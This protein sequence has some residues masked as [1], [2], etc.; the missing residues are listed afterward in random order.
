MLSPVQT[1]NFYGYVK[2]SLMLMAS[3]LERTVRA[4]PQ[5]NVVAVSQQAVV[6]CKT[7]ATGEGI[8]S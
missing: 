6:Q 5:V 2:D 8:G 4:E 3:E 1:I 7:V